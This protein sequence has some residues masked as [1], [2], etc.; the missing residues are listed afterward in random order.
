MPTMRE[1]KVVKT[2]E[3][4]KCRVV[5]VSFKSPRLDCFTNDSLQIRIAKFEYLIESLTNCPS[6]IS[7]GK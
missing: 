5:N 4:S 7:V 3:V 1:I 2:G 6:F